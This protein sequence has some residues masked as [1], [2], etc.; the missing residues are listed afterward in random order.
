[1]TQQDADHTLAPTELRG[2]AG[3]HLLLAAIVGLL[4]GTI[5]LAFQ[6]ASA[7]VSEAQSYLSFGYSV[8]FLSCL[9]LIAGCALAGAVAGLLTQYVAPEA[10]G[11]GIPHIKAVLAHEQ[12]LRGIRILL[13]K[14]F[15][16]ALVIGSKFSLG[17]EGPTVHLGAALADDLSKRAKAP[18]HL[19]DHLIACGAGAGLA[20]AFNAPLAGFLFVIEELRRES[21]SITIGMA[22]IGAVLADSIVQIGTGSG[23]ILPVGPLEA[24]SIWAIPVI[25]LIALAATATGLLFNQALVT[26]IRKT[27]PSI[28]LWLRGGVAGVVVGCAIYFFNPLT[29]SL[30]GTFGLYLTPHPRSTDALR[31]IFGCGTLLIL[32]MLL[33]VACYATGVPGGIFAPMLVQGVFVGILVGHLSALTPLEVPSP[34]VCALIGMT[35]LFAAS[36]RAPFTGVVLL[37]EMTG[38]FNLLLP[39]MAAA[40]IAYLAAE[41]SGS[42]PI[43]ERLMKT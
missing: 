29:Q 42:K 31:I 1:M 3:R 23:P 30:E 34:V 38:A 8:P 19:R 20:A 40:L 41:L 12:N 2:I 18:Q 26:A 37:A 6:K 11:S 28:P 15:G 17:R 4:V 39:L 25:A 35:A 22:L 10:K 16:G 32:K 13:A 27:P 5:A 7:V 33:T 36:V 9:S 14:F 21:S 24:P 43:Y